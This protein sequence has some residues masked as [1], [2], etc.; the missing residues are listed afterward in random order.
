MSKKPSVVVTGA[1]GFVGQAV[2]RA[3]LGHGEAVVALGRDPAKLRQLAAWGAVA[4]PVA[5]EQ[6]AEV[7]AALAGARAVVHAAARSSPW[8]S[9]AEFWAANVLGTHHVVA[10][11]QTHFIPRL[12]HLSSPAVVFAGVDQHHCDESM[13]YLQQHISLYGESKQASEQL[14]LAYPG[15]IVLRPKAIYGPGDTALLPRLVAAARARRLP[16]IG[17]GENCIDITYIDDVVAAILLAIDAPRPTAAP[18]YTIT[19]GEHVPLWPFIGEI[20]QHLGLPKPRLRLSVPAA[21]ALATIGEFWGQLR[22]QEP[23]LTRYTALL[24]ACQQTYSI[25]KAQT[26]LGYTP[27]VNHQQG[28]AR[29]LQAWH[30]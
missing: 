20:L 30:D 23:L 14:A 9:R 26:E 8:G 16:Q 25:A 18:L 17:N 24:L 7:M 6:R 11:C 12:V 13:P 1:S 3:L 10:A 21:L 19:G 5:L 29:V 15:T 4:V 28:L 2:V 27:T 22:N